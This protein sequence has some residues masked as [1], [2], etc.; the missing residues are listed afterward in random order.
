MAASQGS[1]SR[2][3]SRCTAETARATV[4][5]EIAGYRLLKGHGRGKCLR[6]PAFSIGGYEWR[7][8]YYPDGN[9]SEAAEGYVSLF[10]ELLTEKAEVRATFNFMI[11]EPVERKS[12]L[13]CSFKE[14]L[15]FD[16]ERSSWGVTNFMKTTTE[17]ESVYLRNDC[18][19]IECEVSVIKETLEVHVPPSRLVDN[20]AKLL[21]GKKGADVTFK[22][23]GEVFSAHKVLL[24]TQSAVFDAE[25][26]GPMGGKGAQDITIDGMQPAVFKSFLHFIYTDSMP[27]MD[28]L[29]DDDK[30]EMVKHLL[31]AADK[32]AMERMKLICEG[33]LC[34]SLD[35]ENVAT[36]LALADQ[37]NC[38]NL[39]DACMEF[40]LSSNRMNDVIASQG[41]VQLKRSSPD[42]IVD[43]LERAAKSRKI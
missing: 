13:V 10:L 41:Y 23:Q 12:I 43:V 29:E 34:K 1:I 11:V 14:P 27:S 21:E 38:S 32:Y 33:M 5:F 30:R 39:K 35:V 17:V 9:Q 18:L 6:S 3:P 31:V 28:D 22:V 37:H 16:P 25:F 2:M 40:M 20:L 36:I 8:R 19:V 7:I 26:Y 4:A 15:V 24:A 42:I